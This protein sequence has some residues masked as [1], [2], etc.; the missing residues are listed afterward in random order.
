MIINVT[1]EIELIEAFNNSEATNINIA[2]GVYHLKDTLFLG[3]NGISVTGDESNRPILDFSKAKH[4]INGFVIECDNIQIKNIIIAYSGNKGLFAKTNNSLFSNIETYGN[5]DCGFQLKYSSNTKVID[6]CSH[7]NFGY[8]TMKNGKPNFGFNSDGFCDKQY[9][10]PGN[11]WINC[12]AWNNSDDGFDFY[13][14][15]T[16]GDSPTVIENCYSFNNGYSEKDISKN[17]RVK[18]DYYFLGACG[19]DLT[20]YPSY[21]NGNGFKLGGGN[22]GHSVIINNCFVFNNK[23]N[24]FTQNNNNG[25]VELTKCFAVNNNEYNFGFNSEDGELLTVNC[26]TLKGLSSIETKNYKYKIC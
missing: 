25:K 1:N 20:K 22:K 23:R 8:M 19:Y 16:P 21:G 11:T 18:T 13:E 15:I 10:G 17:P 7:D 5:C 9:E 24:G 4:G 6:C 14:R 2:S 3:I 12:K 26:I